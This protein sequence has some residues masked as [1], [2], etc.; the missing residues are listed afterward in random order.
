M[1][2]G[3]KLVIFFLFAFYLVAY[4]NF[5]FVFFMDLRGDMKK[6]KI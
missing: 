1:L 5:Q 6:I 3:F 4:K 2:I